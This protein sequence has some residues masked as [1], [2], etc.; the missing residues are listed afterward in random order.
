MSLQNSL[1]QTSPFGKIALLVLLMFLGILISIVTLMAI[2]AA[3]FHFPLDII[4]HLSATSSVASINAAKSVQIATQIGI[5]I[6]PALAFGYLASSSIWKGLSFTRNLS[7]GTLGLVVVITLLAI[8]FINLLAQWNTLWHLPE[9]W[10]SIE[11]WMRQTQLAN[12]QM[13]S[14]LAQ[15]NS[16]SAIIINILMMAILPAIGE[17]LIF[18]GVL[19]TQLIKVFK[20]AHIGILVTA[21]IF[22][23][24]HLQF[25][26]FLSRAILGVLF[27]YVFYYSK[28]IWLPILAHFINNFLALSLVFVYG[29][30]MAET[31]FENPTDW[32]II[33]FA[34]AAIVSAAIL[35]II[36]RS[37]FQ[38]IKS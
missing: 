20:N 23:A 25:L 14:V 18:R 36:N 37:K 38:A 7:L 22:S 9:S 11:N 21:L 5:F 26:G 32:K 12:D 17:E 15:M 8:P 33:S 10:S 29:I 19:Q 6:L 35:L 34:V 30:E 3:F 24:I 4:D 28:N 1:H 31:S 13:I 27:G 2:N 16:P